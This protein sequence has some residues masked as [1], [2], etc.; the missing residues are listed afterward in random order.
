MKLTQMVMLM[1]VNQN[2]H[3]FLQ[4]WRLC[5]DRSSELPLS[6]IITWHDN[7][8]VNRFIS[9]CSRFV[10][11]YK[12]SFYGDY[13]YY[14][15]SHCHL[16][17]SPAALVLHAFLQNETLSTM[18]LWWFTLITICFMNTGH[19]WQNHWTILSHLLC[20]SRPGSPALVWEGSPSDRSQ[21]R[22]T[23]SH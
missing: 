23:R 9:K 8:S 14:V 19:L 11:G 6:K 20:T 5:S 10:F 17:S 1:S 7:I 2:W 15:S 21:S 22:Y 3:L 4:L 16:E 12:F 18:W 13:M